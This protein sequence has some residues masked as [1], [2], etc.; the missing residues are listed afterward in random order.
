[1]SSGPETA[2]PSST[3]PVLPPETLGGAG[4]AR[5]RR[6][7]RRL[8]WALAIYSAVV[9][10]LVTGVVLL[11][12]HSAR[13]HAIVLMALGLLG[14]WVVAGGLLSW[15]YRDAVR[16]AMR[17]WRWPWPLRFF[18]L[19]L[20]LIL[21]EEAITTAMTNLAPE[22]GSTLGVAYI[23]ASA[24]YL[25]VIAFSSV[26]V[27]A[28]AFA[29]WAWLLSR[30]RFTP[31]EVFLLFGLLGTTAEASLNPSA[32]FAGYWFFVYGLMVYLPTYSL[33]ER[34]RAREPGP[35]AYVLS[36]LV[37]LACQIPAVVV[38]SLLKAQ[39]GIRLFTG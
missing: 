19:A 8:I 33:P 36:Y 4:G 18:L 17:R 12:S 11:G 26:S 9:V 38:V 39:L 1:M 16:A 24:N 35:G 14:L 2:G 3:G 29:G 10:A 28:P 21:V 13:E 27:I 32:L 22:F 7:A 37:P 20:A 34:P 15:R 5:R 31:E 25:E 23:T 30:Y 6:W